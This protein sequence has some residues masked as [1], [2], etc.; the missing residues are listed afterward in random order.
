MKGQKLAKVQN[1]KKQVDAENE[2]LKSLSWSALEEE[3][4]LI[5]SKFS[6]VDSILEKKYQKGDVRLNVGG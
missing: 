3:F 5:K 4:N 2:K 6:D 1:L